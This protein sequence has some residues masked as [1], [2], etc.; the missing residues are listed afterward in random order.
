VAGTRRRGPSKRSRARPVNLAL[1]GGGA[2]GAFT[3]GVLDR[4]LEDQR[5]AIEGISGTSAGAIN[6]LM[7]AYGM[8]LDGRD[9]AR[10][11]L[12]QLWR[13]IGEA[14][15]HSPF[16]PSWLDRML[17]G[18]NLDYSP[19]FQMF[20]LMS[21]VIS[22]YQSNPMDLHPLRDLLTDMVDFD[23]L[24]ACA[25]EAV[26][27]FVSTTDVRSG[28]IRVFGPK[29]LRPEVFMASACLPLLFKAVEIDGEHYWDGGYMGNPAL[30]PL[31]YNCRA[32]DIML[33]EINPIRIEEVPTDSRAILD[34]VNDISFNATMMR[35]MRA[36]AFVTRMLDQHKIAG[37]SNLRR[38]FFHMV[39][40]EKAM[41]RYGASSKFNTT[42][43]FL[44]T[45]FKLG[46]QTA[47]EWLDDHFSAIGRDSSVDLHSLF[48]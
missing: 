37:G 19:G 40:A 17:G 18:G 20:D 16:Q 21:R 30:F 28:K 22:P 32:S 25:S 34:R 14:A 33:V 9:G 48:F 29:E 11:M 23:R 36:I 27:L 10:A 6:G 12:A 39:Q 8:A 7:V 45:L 1:Q 13:R 38:I 42:P 24:R 43:D 15:R 4:L 46:R 3:W 26:K 41:A 31:I 35:E 2:H 47:E 44:D 5:I